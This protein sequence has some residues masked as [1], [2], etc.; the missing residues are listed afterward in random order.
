MSRK[1]TKQDRALVRE[2]SPHLEEYFDVMGVN[3][4][5]ADRMD[6]LAAMVEERNS[7]A[8]SD[9]VQDFVRNF[10]KGSGVK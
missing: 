2:L 9:P 6:I 4:S 7:Q 8:I 1:Y 3:V 5:P 10:L